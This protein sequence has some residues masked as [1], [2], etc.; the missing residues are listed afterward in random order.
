MYFNLNTVEHAVS[1]RPKREDLVVAYRRWSFTRIEPQRVSSETE[2][3]RHIYSRKIIHRMHFLSVVLCVVPCCR[4][5]D[6]SFFIR[7][8]GLVGFRE[9]ANRKK[10]A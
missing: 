7:E 1:D 5:R 6:R 9:G 10:L 4:L 8:G 3:S 2:R